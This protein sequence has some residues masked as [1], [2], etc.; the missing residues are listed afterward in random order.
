MFG[1][2]NTGTMNFSENGRSSP[3]AAILPPFIDPQVDM[4]LS[5]EG[6]SEALKKL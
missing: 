4:I 6:S 5:S 2:L 1:S 3:L